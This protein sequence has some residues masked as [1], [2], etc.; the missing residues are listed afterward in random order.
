MRN[1][2]SHAAGCVGAYAAAVSPI[3]YSSWCVRT[4]C[5]VVRLSFKES[6][7]TDAYTH[8]NEYLVFLVDRVPR[9]YQTRLS[10][11]TWYLEHFGSA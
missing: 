5:V 9:Y 1:L 8:R 4:F 7:W 10:V 2:R 11:S 6:L 3:T